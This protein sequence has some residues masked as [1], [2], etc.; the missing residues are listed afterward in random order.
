MNRKHF[1]LAV[2]VFIV[3]PWLVATQSTTTTPPP[4]P[5]PTSD[6]ELPLPKHKGQLKLWMVNP[7]TG[8][9]TFVGWV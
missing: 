6:T 9:K 1:V 3:L 8:Q 2:L 7:T 5:N 4:P